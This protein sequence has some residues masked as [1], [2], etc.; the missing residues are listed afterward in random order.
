MAW[1]LISH[2]SRLLRFSRDIRELVPSEYQLG[3]QTTTSKCYLSELSGLLQDLHLPLT[4]AADMV[5]VPLTL[6]HDHYLL[7]PCEK[8]CM[9]CVY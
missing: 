7:Q 2:Q 9:D 1:S 8:T 4:T 3:A 6:D 5:G